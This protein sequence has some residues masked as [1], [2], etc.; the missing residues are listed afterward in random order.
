M[1][2]FMQRLPRMRGVVVITRLSDRGRC[3]AVLLPGRRL[4]TQPASQ[5]WPQV[6]DCVCPEICAAAERGLMKSRE[7]DGLYNSPF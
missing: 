1:Q 5:Q 6:S 3:R 2:G 7:G 4:K